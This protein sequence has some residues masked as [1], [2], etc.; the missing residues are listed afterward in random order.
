MKGIQLFIWVP[1]VWK[2]SMADGCVS[3]EP[4]AILF[5][6]W[7]GIE[8]FIWDMGSEHPTDFL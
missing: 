7:Y 6:R 5:G 1:R 4:R 3:L 8:L 2:G